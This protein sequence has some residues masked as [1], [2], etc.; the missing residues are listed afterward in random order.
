MSLLRCLRTFSLCHIDI[1][2]RV[3]V[4]VFQSSGMISTAR[5]VSPLH[6]SLQK[7]NSL[8]VIL[9]P[10]V[11]IHIFRLLQT[12][13]PLACLQ[14]RLALFSILNL[15]IDNVQFPAGIALK[16]SQ[17]IASLAVSFLSF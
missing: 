13:M 3:S 2:S 12:D 7:Y 11:S 9:I 16:A 10:P 14:Y 5:I 4:D 15:L 6:R 17:L 8:N 1:D